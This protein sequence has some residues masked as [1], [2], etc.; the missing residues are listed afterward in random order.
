MSDQ[1]TLLK[2]FLCNLFLFFLV[3]AAVFFLLLARFNP[4]AEENYL[5]ATVDKHRRLAQ[6]RP[7][8]VILVGGSNLALG[9]QSD[10]LEVALGRPVVNMGLAQ[11]LGLEFMLNEVQAAIGSGDTVV[12]SVEYNLLTGEYD[13]LA[14]EQ[15]ISYRPGNIRYLNYEQL[16]DL[17]IDHGLA[18]F[19]ELARRA[20]YV[21]RSAS[22]RFAEKQFPYARHG[23]NQRG[24]FTAHYGL[25]QTN[26]PSVLLADGTAPQINDT[27]LASAQV[28]G[29]LRVFA[30]CCR[31]RGAV[32][33]YSCPPHPPD[34]LAQERPTLEA[35]LNQLKEIRY[36]ER[37]DRPEDQVYPRDQ[38]F[39]SIYHL[40]REGTTE[41]TERLIRS[42]R[43][44]LPELGAPRF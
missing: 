10:R 30:D 18:L 6:T 24:D 25:A 8:R 33:V 12:L 32:V 38:F 20:I 3:Q 37:I 16:T 40:T 22:L 29:R 36:L 9:I 44:Y 15:V 27:L 39:D 41:R 2:R 35:I 7:P 1:S 42:L 4:D 21:D 28:L 26:M 23:F 13:K 5:A 31:Q 43:K 19:C 34:Y 14:L 11:G 17:L